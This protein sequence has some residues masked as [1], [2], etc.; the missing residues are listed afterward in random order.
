M[1]KVG[2]TCVGGPLDGRELDVDLDDEGLPPEQVTETELFFAY[3]SELL[4]ADTSGHY[5]V[6]SIGA[7]RTAPW[8]F[9]W[10]PRG[11]LETT[12]EG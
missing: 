9:V 2:I 11:H 5:E 1:A 6:E 4:D 10:V 12:G 3:G 7:R 8:V